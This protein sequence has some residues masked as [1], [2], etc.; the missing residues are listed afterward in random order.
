MQKFASESNYG[1]K[2]TA[3]PRNIT[4]GQQYGFIPKLLPSGYCLL[5]PSPLRGF[6]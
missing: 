2:L 5:Y 3:R 4:A 1:K 6:L